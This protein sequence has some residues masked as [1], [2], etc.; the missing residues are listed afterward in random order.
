MDR[1]GVQAL[2][3]VLVVASWV[4]LAAQVSEVKPGPGDE[5]VRVYTNEDL[6]RLAPL[7]SLVIVDEAGEPLK[8]EGAE[9]RWAFVE[10][11]VGQAYARIDADRA[12]WMERRRTEAEAKAL[13]RIHSRPRYL[14]PINFY[15]RGPVVGPGPGHR[16][17]RD[18]SRLWERPNAHL[19]RPITPI[20]AR[21]YQTN[22]HRLGARQSARA[23]GR[24][25]GQTGGR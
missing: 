1:R 11:V 2:G 20:H 24:G 8:I 6:D 14:M 10:S 13:E 4:P 21:P 23:G 3:A 17:R 5:P 25:G 9:E 18:A 7:P 16:F 12:Y 22:L 19:F 15:N